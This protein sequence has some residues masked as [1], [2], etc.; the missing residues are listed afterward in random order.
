MET[1]TVGGLATPFGTAIAQLLAASGGRV[2]L[3]SGRRTYAEQAALRVTNG[4][5][6]V[7]SSPASSCRVPTARPGESQHERGL[8]ADL[9]G[10]LAWVRS[11]AG[12]YG[13]HAPVRGEPWHWEPL[14]GATGQTGT[15]LERIGN[16]IAGAA[17]DASGGVAGVIEDVVDALRRWSV[18]AL[19]TVAGA[20]LL[21]TGAVNVATGTT[22]RERAKA[23][24]SAA[25]TVVTK[26]AV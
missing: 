19:F 1:S 8:A 24:L 5:P 11:V 18:L 13:I 10:D 21:V 23:G 9:G 3:T 17:G 4:C 25:A 22:A 2:T 14:N 20:A 15:T 26:G 12:Q 6:D 16:T 7:Y